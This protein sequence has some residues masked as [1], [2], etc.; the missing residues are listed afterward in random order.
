VKWVGRET[1]F[2]KDVHSRQ[3]ECQLGQNAETSLSKPGKKGEK[4]GIQ[5]DK[6]YTTPPRCFQLWKAG[7][8]L[9]ASKKEKK[10]TKLFARVSDKESHWPRLWRTLV[11]D[12]EINEIYIEKK[13][14]KEQYEPTNLNPTHMHDRLKELCTFLDAR[15]AKALSHPEE[16]IV[17][18]TYEMQC[19]A[20][21][22]FYLQ[23]FPYDFQELN[24]VVRMAKDI[25]DPLLRHIVPLAH[26]KAFF[27]SGRGRGLVSV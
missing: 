10:P 7:E 3:H 25:T 12:Q 2:S 8:G 24:I 18:V 9:L 14:P 15:R 21:Q 16:G 22:A 23:K 19:E 11:S 20:R 17:Y 1:E 13:K 26:D 27:C 4:S 6:Y 5:G